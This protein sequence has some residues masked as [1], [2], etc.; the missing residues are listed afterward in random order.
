[1]NPINKRIIQYGCIR[2]V[3]HHPLGECTESASLVLVSVMNCL[4]GR[5]WLHFV[6][7]RSKVNAKCYIN[8]LLPNVVKDCYDLFGNNI[9]F[10]KTA[11]AHIH[12]CIAK[13]MQQ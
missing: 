5:W 2:K 10:Q 8:N 11:H 4:D 1:M 3:R 9:V 13:K 12:I 7:E 6:E